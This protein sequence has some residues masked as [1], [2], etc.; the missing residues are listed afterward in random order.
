MEHCTEELEQH[1]NQTLT[2]TTNKEIDWFDL[3]EPENKWLVD[4][5]IPSDG[6][7]LISGKPKCGKSTF[8]RNLVVSIVKKRQF[9]DRSIDV[10]EGTGKVLYIHLDQKDKTPRVAAELRQLGITREESKRII[11]RT[12]EHIPM[13]GDINSRLT[14]LAEQVKAAKPHLIVI[15]LLWQFLQGNNANEYQ[16][17][18]KE[19]NNLQRTLRNAGYNGA[20]IAAT[21]SRKAVN[22]DNPADDILGA[23]SQ[24]GSFVTTII[25]SRNTRQDMYT[26]M[27]DQTIKDP[28]YG[29]IKETV[30]HRNE[31]GI[32]DLGMKICD[33]KAAETKDKDEGALRR[34]EIFIHQNPGCVEKQIK[35]GLTISWNRALELMKRTTR[36]RIEG[37]G[38]KS[39][40]KKYYVDALDVATELTAKFGN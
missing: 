23:T 17:V 15:D 34:L 14:W 10:A 21:H 37:K 19:V 22:P 26:I 13:D 20:L 3:E 8:I 16:A 7:A 27:T 25:L 28:F 5:L 24:S 32:M 36:I 1:T 39:D 33:L 11:L 18:L 6:Y 2:K 35:E 30:I 12:D 4:G 9:L 29:D 38:V 31:D 40:P